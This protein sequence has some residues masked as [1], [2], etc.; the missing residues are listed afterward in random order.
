M[1][2]EGEEFHNNLIDVI[3]N[4]KNKNFKTAA[5]FLLTKLCDKYDGLSSFLI[6]FSLQL[7][8]Y[9]LNGS[10]V[11]NISKYNILHSVMKQSKNELQGESSPNNFFTSSSSTSENFQIGIKKI[12]TNFNPEIQMDVALLILL[13][14]NTNVTRS[15]SFLAILRLILETHSDKIYTIQSEIIKDKLCLLFGTFLDDLYSEDEIE[16]F[17]N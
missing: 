2:V 8:D 9:C 5:S 12:I 1:K 17:L 15:S 14:L 13:I 10:D 6:N 11:N 7:I 16:Q 4:H 3:Q